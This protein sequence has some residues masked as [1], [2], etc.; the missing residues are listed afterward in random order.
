MYAMQLI[1]WIVFVHRVHYYS[2]M[3]PNVVTFVTNVLYKG[4]KN[5]QLLWPK[6]FVAAVA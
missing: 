5:V 4:H 3:Q 6:V 1:K 2:I